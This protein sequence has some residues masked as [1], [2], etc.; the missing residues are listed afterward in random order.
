MRY[1]IDGDLC[2]GHGRCYSLAPGVFEA[3]DDGFNAERGSEGEVE[4]G[5]EDTAVL[6]A[7]SCPEQAIRIVRVR[8]QPISAD[9]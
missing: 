3:D 8:T 6:G 1:S 2:T 9:G 4:P 5:R 7:E